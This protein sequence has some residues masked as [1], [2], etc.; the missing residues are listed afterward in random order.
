M[1][2]KLI[3]LRHFAPTFLQSATIAIACLHGLASTGFA[4]DIVVVPF[5]QAN[6]AMPHLAHE[7]ANLTLKAVVRNATPGQTYRVSW[8]TNRDGNYENDAWKEYT[9]DSNGSIRDIGRTYQT[10]MVS[11]TTN[12]N[13]GVRIRNTSNNQDNFNTFRLKTYDFKP[14]N[15]PRNWTRLQTTVMSAM[16]VQETM[17]NL[18]RN[19]TDVTG[20]GAAIKAKAAFTI[21]T[22][23]YIQMFAENGHMPA[24]APGT[25]SGPT[26]TGWNGANDFRWNTDPYA[27]TVL[28]L[29]NDQISQGQL[30]TSFSTTEEQNTQGYNANGTART[31]SR[32]PGTTDGRGIQLFGGS[33]GLFDAGS[34]GDHGAMTAALSHVLPVLAGT[35][36]QVGPTG[37]IGKSYEHITQQAVDYLG[38]AQT[39]SG[40]GKGGWYYSPTNGSRST[41]IP[42]GTAWARLGL[43]KA[44]TSGNSFGIVVPNR[45]EYRTADLVLAMQNGDGGYKNL[46]NGASGIYETAEM[47][48][49]MRSMGVQNFSRFDNAVAFPNESSVTRGQL[50]T[51]FDNAQA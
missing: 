48:L 31:V 16:S 5:S 32:L 44:S 49:G 7:N 21:A 35:T 9:V 1:R 23:N 12:S 24:Y 4:A 6:P 39:D 38:Y 18:H 42:D 26:P 25:Y 51:S 3:E 34:I 2:L 46:N 27:E 36:A 11:N 14:S 19:V 43:E 8:D 13:I 40:N 28:R 41:H 15:D 33:G 10:G 22:P 30:S 20:T 47:V 45:T 50:R 17:W 29:V 37:V